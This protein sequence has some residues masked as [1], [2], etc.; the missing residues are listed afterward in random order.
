M[1]L[2]Y[3]PVSEPLHIYD[4]TLEQVRDTRVQPGGDGGHV[5]R[6]LGLRVRPGHASRPP[7]PTRF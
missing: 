5:P 1:G 6:T 2:E 3:E 7:G 4:Y